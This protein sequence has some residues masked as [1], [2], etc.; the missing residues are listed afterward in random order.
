MAHAVAP[1]DG[2]PVPRFIFG[3]QLG[4]LWVEDNSGGG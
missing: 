1:C 4:G 3:V 2:E